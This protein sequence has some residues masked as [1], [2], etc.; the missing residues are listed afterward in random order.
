MMRKWEAYLF[1][2]VFFVFGFFLG[3]YALA[4]M[5]DTHRPA[6]PT[7]IAQNSLAFET[8]Q[9]NECA[10]KL[11]TLQAIQ[12]QTNRVATILYEPSEG[13]SI[14]V[15]HGLMS[16]PIGNGGVATPKWWVPGKTKPLILNGT[17]MAYQYQYL[18]MQTQKIDG[19]YLALHPVRQ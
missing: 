7:D 3:G 19:P 1:A 4:R 10:V 14:P 5:E 18:D 6:Q 9:A 12:A 17:G 15:L 2:G 11:I 16:I 8:D 13:T